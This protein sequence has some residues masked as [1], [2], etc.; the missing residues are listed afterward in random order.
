MYI[1]DNNK[2]SRVE[3]RW[4]LCS[5]PIVLLC[6]VGPYAAGGMLYN[7]QALVSLKMKNIIDAEAC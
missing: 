3:Q 4:W 7:E 1:L 6:R 5:P 2:S